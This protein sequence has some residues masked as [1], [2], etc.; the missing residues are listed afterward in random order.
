VIGVG[1][2][3]IAIAEMQVDAHAACERSAQRD[4]SDLSVTVNTTHPRSQSKH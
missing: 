2:R 4:H 3:G 1:E